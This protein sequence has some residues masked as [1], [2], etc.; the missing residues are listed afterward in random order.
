VGFE[1]G[2]FQR[3]R[4]TWADNKYGHGPTGRAI[5]TGKIC[6]ANDFL[7]DPELAPWRKLAVERGFRSSIALP[8]LTE[9][10]AFG[11]LTIYAAEPAAFD[12][13]Q[14]ELLIE[15]ADDLSFGISGLRI[16]AERDRVRKDLETTTVQ[17]RKLTAELAQTEER[18]RRRVASVL[19]DSIQ[20]LLV[21]ARY[22]VETLRG[23]S[24][25]EAF[26]Q[27]IQHVDG[28]LSNCLETSRSLTLELSPPILY[29]A[30][31]AP[32]LKW[33]GRWFRQTHGLTVR[34]V[35][36]DRAL[37]DTEPIRVVVYHAVRELLFNIVKHAKV[38][39]AQVRMSGVGENRIKILV[40]DKGVGLEPARL[41]AGEGK[42]GGFGL[43][44][45]RE[46][47]ASLGGHME[48]ESAPGR[49]SRFTLIVPLGQPNAEAGAGSIPPA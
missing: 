44:S 5:R 20:Q 28:L 34:V 25:T 26:Q 43:F 46:R 24:R 2:Y 19:H 9:G 12:Q 13:K 32:A 11:A 48:V 35:A 29:E 1:E 3:A 30:G 17:L 14:I 31:L 41:Q 37:A 40:T 4:I 45:L 15:L 8:L 27:T 18:E 36:E 39:R 21:G 6:M 16:Q 22:G 47:L 7:S 38:R 49:G 10:R 23:H 42:T 33:L